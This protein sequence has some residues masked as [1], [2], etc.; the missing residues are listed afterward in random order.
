MDGLRRILLPMSQRD[1]ILRPI[2]RSSVSFASIFAPDDSALDP[3]IEEDEAGNDMKH[4]S[5]SPSVSLDMLPMPQDWRNGGGPSLTYKVGNS[6]IRFQRP[7]VAALAVILFAGCLIL[8]AL[9]G[10]GVKRGGRYKGH[11]DHDHFHMPPPDAVGAMKAPYNATY[12]LSQPTITVSG[13]RYRVGL[14]ADL[15]EQSRVEGKQNVWASEYKQGYLYYDSSTKKAKLE[16][17]EGD[18]VV[19]KSS[20]ALGGRG[21]ELSELVVFNGKLYSVDDR[22]GVVYQVVGGN[23]VVPWAIL[24]DGNGAETKGFKSE[25]IVHKHDCIRRNQALHLSDPKDRTCWHAGV[26]CCMRFTSD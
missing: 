17:D 3:L 4:S 25:Y 19:L 20:L 6:T 5:S 1:P 16:W 22:T 21:M 7:L 18:A 14:I 15:D 24:S 9:V 11:H 12:P 26:H 13:M 8:Y 23:K 2:Q 10:G